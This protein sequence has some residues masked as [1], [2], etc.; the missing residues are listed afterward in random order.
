[1]KTVKIFEYRKEV[2]R[3]SEQYQKAIAAFSKQFKDVQKMTKLY[4]NDENRV[5]AGEWIDSRGTINFNAGFAPDVH[6]IIE[7]V[8]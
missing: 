7:F 6:R 8:D 5:Y 2:K 4:I 3:N 1:M